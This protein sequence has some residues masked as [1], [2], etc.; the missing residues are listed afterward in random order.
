[1]RMVNAYKS[2]GWTVRVIR[3]DRESSFRAIES[4]LNGE[5]L[6]CEY[7]GRGM[8]E[9]R[10][11]R[12]IRIVK[13]RVR[14]LRCT[15]VYK[16]PARLN[17]AAVM[18]IVTTLNM[19]PNKRSGTQSPREVITG[20]KVNAP[21]D[22]R[23][24]FGKLVLVKVPNQPSSDDSNE[25]RVEDGI[26]VGRDHNSNGL[27]IFLL[28]NARIVSRS[29]FKPCLF[30]PTVCARL[31][32]HVEHDQSPRSRDP[33]IPYE[34]HPNPPDWTHPD[35]SGLDEPTSPETAVPIPATGPDNIL[36]P[37]SDSPSDQ[38]SETTSGSAPEHENQSESPEPKSFAFNISVKEAFRL[39]TSSAEDFIVQEMD[40]L[41]KDKRVLRVNLQGR[42]H[43]KVLPSSMFCKEKRPARTN[44]FE[45]LKARLVGGGHMTDRT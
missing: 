31:N 6:Q 32:D 2:Y 15:Q 18:D 26:V 40:Q 1:M 21:R 24:E 38:T 14:I 7:T 45:K 39:H 28:D 5:G 10:A 13:E 19:T 8:H 17:E 4:T 30:T 37:E 41:F 34:D 29:T 42:K 3:T 44:D 20:K 9:R 33:V 12:A 43:I 23:V 16:L 22:I 25:P 36:E 27:K 11:E 35:A